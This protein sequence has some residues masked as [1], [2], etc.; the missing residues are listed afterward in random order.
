VRVRSACPV[1]ASTDLVDVTERANVPVHQNKLY[2]SPAAARGITRGYLKVVACSSCTFVFN[3]A[4]DLSLMS[5]N[6]SYENDQTHSPA[7]SAHV[8]GLVDL[9]LN[10]RGVR[11]NRI[12]EVGSGKGT[13][14]KALVEGDP[15]NVGWG[16]DP[17]YTGPLTAVEGRV[18]YIRSFYDRGYADLAPDAVICRHVIEHVPEPLSLLTEIRRASTGARVFV[19]TPD[20]EWIFRNGVLWDLFYEHCSYFSANSFAVAFQRAGFTSARCTRI[21]GDQYLWV[22]AGGDRQASGCANEA[23]ERV[24]ALAH[25]FAEKE[26]RA[27]AHWREVIEAMK[28]K[29]NVALW[30]AGAKGVTAASLF[31]PDAHLISCVIDLN[32]AKQNRFVAGTGHPILA[33]SALATLGVQ[34]VLLMNP[35]YE[36]EV[37]RLLATEHIDAEL[38]L[39]TEVS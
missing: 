14:L 33:P 32:P 17:A 2:D 4:F 25:K 10:E 1:C 11:E 29:G 34:S 16:F 27:V 12:I 23:P 36:D 31:D 26:T 37:R 18:E 21:F 15:G 22:E 35:N 30:G 8:D 28:R 6:E 24:V 7:F 38:I 9:L 19:E 5:Y 39:D 20:V 3:A 13:F